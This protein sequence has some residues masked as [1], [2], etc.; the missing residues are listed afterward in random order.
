MVHYDKCPLCSSGNISLKLKTTDYF[1]SKEPFSIFHCSECGFIFTQ[2]HP[3]EE[4]SARYYESEDYLSHGDAKNDFVS[5]I[6]R[7]SREIMLQKKVK[8]V[9]DLSGISTGTILDIGS[10]TGHFLNSMKKAGWDVKGIEINRKA[11]DFSIASFALDVKEP[12][13][14]EYLKPETFDCITLWHVLEHFHDPFGYAQHIHRLLKPCGICII[15]LPNCS[16]FDAEY[17]GSFWAAYDVPRHIWHF[18]T[19]TFRRFCEQTGFKVTEIRSLPLDVFYISFLS[20][21]YKGANLPFLSGMIKGSW[22]RLLTLFNKQRTSSMT[23]VL[24]PCPS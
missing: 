20:E 19:K 7:F 18:S 3:D 8:L 21:K 17:F 22:F 16:S 15:A 4:K 5:R 9:Q 13:Q 2:D 24:T 6:Y 12:A 23:Y 10:G 11:R 1:L 14:L